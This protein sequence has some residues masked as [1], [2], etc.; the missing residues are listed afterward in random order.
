M[1]VEFISRGYDTTS[2]KPYTEGFWAD[3]HSIKPIGSARYGVLGVND[4]KVTPVAGA[5]RTVSIAPGHGFG[6]GVTDQTVANETLQFDINT[7]GTRYDLVVVRR[8]WTPTA[9]VSK[10]D[11]VKGS[12]SKAIPGT[13]KSGQ[14]VEDDQPIALVPIVAGQTQPGTI[15]DLRCWT[16][17]GG[18]IAKDTL[19]LGYLAQLGACVLIG[20]TTWRYTFGTNGVA[21][22]VSDAPDSKPIALSGGYA[23]L[24]AGY[25]APY[26]R[27]HADGLVFM[28]GAIG[29]SGSSVNVDQ[30]RPNRF[31]VGEIDAAHLPAG[32]ETFDPIATESMGKVFLYVYPVGHAKAGW[33]EFEA[34]VA[35]GV[36]PKSAF[37]ILLTG[38]FSW[39]AA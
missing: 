8:D 15:I 7:T 38:G 28:G 19:A 32:I 33:V 1:P 31:K 27:K 25:V 2:D 30:A 23:A 18:V 11:I 37:S 26:T 20:S 12:A 14:G 16:S 21:G 10:F 34:T 36:I 5:D 22:W 35:A 4:W 3:A 13:R 17:N 9:G 29:A 24:G 6:C 39:V